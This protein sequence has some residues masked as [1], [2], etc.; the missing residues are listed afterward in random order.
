MTDAVSCGPPASNVCPYPR[1][2][3]LGR[4]TLAYSVGVLDS[5][6]PPSTAWSLLILGVVPFAMAKL[7]Q[8]SAPRTVNAARRSKF[9]EANQSR[10]GLDWRD[11]RIGDEGER[12][13]CGGRYEF[14]NHANLARARRAGR[15]RH[16]PRTRSNDRIS[17]RRTS[18]AAARPIRRLIP[19]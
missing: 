8:K 12:R 5:F 4:H 16:S 18:C 9:G 15:R 11:R 1:S 17:W 6:H 19:G 13:R 10:S 14:V 2:L 3:L 7:K